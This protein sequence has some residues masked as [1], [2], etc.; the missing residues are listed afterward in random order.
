MRKSVFRKVE[1]KVTRLEKE[2][3]SL[4]NFFIQQKG[5]E[6]HTLRMEEAY[7]SFAPTMRKVYQDLSPL[8]TA[9]LLDL[10]LFLS[11]QAKAGTEGI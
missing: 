4:E 8:E 3:G 6:K 1:N 11:S 10:K 2:Y 7:A 5:C 9:D